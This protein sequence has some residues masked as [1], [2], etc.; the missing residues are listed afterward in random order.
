MNN[1]FIYSKENDINASLSET[2]YMDSSGQSSGIYIGNPPP[3]YY[4]KPTINS[5][6]CNFSGSGELQ[7]YSIEGTKICTYCPEA[8]WSGGVKCTWGDSCSWAKNC[9]WKGW[10]VKC[11]WNLKCTSIQKCEWT[12]L[13]VTYKNNWCDPCWKSPDIVVLPAT[14]VEMTINTN[15]NI[16]Q[17]DPS[18]TLTTTPPTTDVLLTNHRIEIC[19]YD[20]PV[21]N[22]TNV[23]GYNTK[24]TTD[25]SNSGAVDAYLIQTTLVSDYQSTSPTGSFPTIYNIIPGD[26]AQITNDNGYEYQ[27]YVKLDLYIDTNNTSSWIYFRAKITLYIYDSYGTKLDTTSTEFNIN[28]NSLTKIQ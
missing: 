19:D 13:T 1:P 28:M 22:G 3:G 24:L 26:E 18:Y 10:K 16:D 6:K 23:I 20:I 7:P 2:F 5:Y 25:T 9:K 11:D 12:E 15:L 14:T 8:S 4:P 21:Y 27:T 17:F